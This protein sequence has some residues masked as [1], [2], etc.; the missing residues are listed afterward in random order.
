LP[1][2]PAAPAPATGGPI[3][4]EV[5]PLPPVGVTEVTGLLEIVADHG[6]AMDVFALN[7]LTQYDFGHTIAVTKAGE[8]LDLLDTPKHRVVLTGLGR[9]FIAADANG[10]KRLLNAQLRELPIMRFVAAILSRAENQRL[11]ADTVKEELA[12]RLPPTEPADRLFETVVGFGR[13]AE[14]FGYTAA[15][16]ELYLDVEGT[17]GPP[18][19]AE[20]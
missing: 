2:E 1:D 13:H 16:D 8:L 20:V 7:Q 3:P 18:V 12:S 9:A 10:R 17:S 5:E 6:G 4:V 11:P 19:A 15:T 14:L